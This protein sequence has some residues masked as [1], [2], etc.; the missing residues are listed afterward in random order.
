MNLSKNISTLHLLIK[1]TF[2]VLKNEGFTNF[3]K[4]AAISITGTEKIRYKKWIEE[5]ESA[6]HPNS[7]RQEIEKC[8]I[9]PKISVVIPAFDPPINI[10]LEALSSVEKQ[11]YQN[12]EIVVVDASENEK[13]KEILKRKFIKN[14]RVKI[15][16]LGKNL[17]ISGNL[18]EGLKICTGEFIGFLDHDDMLSPTALAEVVKSLNTNKDLDVFYSDEDKIN[19]NGD[20]YKPYFKPSWSPELLLSYNYINHFLVVRKKL[21]DELKGFRKEFD[22]AQDYD[23]VLR[24]T[25]RKIN[26]VHIPKILY[27]WRA[28]LSSTSTDLAVKN[29][30]IE[31]GKNALVEYL[32]R[33]G[34]KGGI[35]KTQYPGIYRTKMDLNQQ[36][37]ISIII[38]TKDKVEILQNCLRSI[39]KSSYKNYEVVVVDN[40]SKEKKTLDYLDEIKKKTNTKIL[41]FSEPFN[42]SKINNF[43]VKN[44]NSEIL[45]FLNNDTQVIN[46]DWIESLLEFAQ[47]NHVGAVG[48]KLFYRNGRIQHAGIVLNLGGGFAGHPFALS[49]GQSTGYFGRLVSVQNYLAVTGACLMVRREI[50]EEVGGFDEKLA[51]AFNDVDLCLKIYQK[52]YLNVWTP[53][54]KLFHHESYSR[55]YNK[56]TDQLLKFREEDE[57]CRNKWKGFLNKSDPY[58]NPNLSLETTNFR[59]KV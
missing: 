29:Y 43:A 33:I 2:R 15:K 25:S 24:L 7:L 56:S 53:Y 35:E 48:A 47:L 19:L 1:K 38:P 51:L 32:K 14:S 57:Y 52:G 59:I 49:E 22:G 3:A 13:I 10:L 42:F 12:W 20:R 21:L 44:T 28:T 23:L 6:L 45:L 40:G 50:F 46:E 36:P 41:K 11:I 34:Q 30:A 54:A 39:E 55:G 9:K 5:N 18:N 26:V 31:A 4:K 8:S 16:F 17:G 58:Y 37:K 27:H